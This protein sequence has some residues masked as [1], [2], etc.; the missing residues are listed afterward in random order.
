MSVLHYEG[1]QTMSILQL[2]APPIAHIGRVH[3]KRHDYAKA[4]Q[5]FELSLSKNDGF[6][7][8]DLLKDHV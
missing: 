3:I 4:I 6:G 2:I 7:V 8:L 5:K 1:N